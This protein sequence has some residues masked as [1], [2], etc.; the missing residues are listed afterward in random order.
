LLD[1]AAAGRG[2]IVL[3][4]TDLKGNAS[5]RSR[6]GKV[7]KSITANRPAA[8]ATLANNSFQF[9]PQKGWKILLFER[10]ALFL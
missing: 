7:E 6:S 2:V 4:D 9:P 3:V 5:M 1:T 10:L 8:F